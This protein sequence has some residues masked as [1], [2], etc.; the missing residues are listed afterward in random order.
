MANLLGQPGAQDF[1]KGIR[2]ALGFDPRARI[3]W[4]GKADSKPG[5]KMGHLNLP[6]GTPEEARAARAAFYEGWTQS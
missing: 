1:R 3:H 5:R 4:Y 2:A 6:H